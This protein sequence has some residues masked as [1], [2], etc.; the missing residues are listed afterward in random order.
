LA[1]Q[2][3]RA[4]PAQGVAVSTMIIS[5]CESNSLI[6]I[7]FSMA[8]PISGTRL[9][10]GIWFAVNGAGYQPTTGDR[11][12]IGLLNPFLLDRRCVEVLGTATRGLA[13]SSRREAT[14]FIQ[15]P[16]RS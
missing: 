13:T 10:D 4:L 3:A 5:G 2:L 1:P 11:R 14:A 8:F 15:A 6:V 9:G 12:L 7:G 16:Q